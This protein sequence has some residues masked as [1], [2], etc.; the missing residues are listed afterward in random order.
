MNTLAQRASRGA[1]LLAISMVALESPFLSAATTQLTP[2][3]GALEC[4]AQDFDG[5]LKRFSNDIEIQKTF[6]STPLLSEFI[7]PEAQP[8][9]RPVSQRLDK[10]QLTF[11]LM[12]S[13]DQQREQGLTLD[14]QITGPDQA[15]I[16][17][18]KADTGYQLSLFFKREACWKLY[19]IQD[20]SL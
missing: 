9:P 14:K 7:D 15:L 18:T 2:P 10:T 1:A 11:P 12:P 3:T 13:E 16:K 5:F 6:V 19:R 20:D 8:E 17:L 4:P